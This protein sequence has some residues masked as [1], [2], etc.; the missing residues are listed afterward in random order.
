MEALGRKSDRDGTALTIS[1]A[2]QFE[3]YE[4]A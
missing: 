4:G 2:T 1:E 3:Q